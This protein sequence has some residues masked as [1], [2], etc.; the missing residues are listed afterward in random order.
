MSQSLRLSKV[1]TDFSGVKTAFFSGIIVNN[2]K[3]RIEKEQ[4]LFL[5]RKNRNQVFGGK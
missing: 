4:I 3:K 5:N 1:V 2:F